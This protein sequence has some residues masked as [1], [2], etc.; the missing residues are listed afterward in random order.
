[1]I[2]TLFTL[3]APAAAQTFPTGNAWVPLPCGNSVMVDLVNDTPNATG[4][5]DIVGTVPAPA[6]FHAADAN[7]AYLRLRVAGNPVNGGRLLRDAWGYE[8]NLDGATDTYQV[9]ISVSGIGTTDVVAIYRH[10]TTTTP[11]DPAEPAVTPPAF[12]YPA[13]MN[14]QYPAAGSTLGGGTDFFV[15]VALPWKDLASV[16]VMPAT[17][18]R[19]WAGTS[20]VA[21]ALNLDLAC[22]AGAGG[23]LGGIDVGVITVDPQG[24]TGGSGGTGGGGAGGSGGGGGNG[25]RGPRTLE[26]GPGCA[27]GG[28]V[29]GGGTWLVFLALVIGTAWGRRSQPRARKS[30]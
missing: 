16:G 14:A 10:P 8:L 20:T 18:V 12:T 30:R 2:L 23:T 4:P 9:L 22:F 27:V 13:A 26:G 25:G 7:F 5:L 24:G 29:D 15:D 3:A 6:G 28:P 17:K 19:L 11:G 1:L 21:N